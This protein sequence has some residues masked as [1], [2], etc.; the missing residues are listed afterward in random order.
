MVARS[1]RVISKQN[2]CC[3]LIIRRS[4]VRVKRA[5]TNHIVLLRSPIPVVSNV[6][7]QWAEDST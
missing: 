7:F 5:A 3:V 1:E 6:D 2:V 4:V